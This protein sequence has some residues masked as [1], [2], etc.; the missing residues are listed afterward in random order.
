MNGRA[1]LRATAERLKAR[2]GDILAPD[3]SFSDP[4]KGRRVDALEDARVRLLGKS[5]DSQ[6]TLELK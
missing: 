5:D 4:E 1:D 3:P 2:F 6:L